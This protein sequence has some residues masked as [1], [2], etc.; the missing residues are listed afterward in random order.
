M[1]LSE[2]IRYEDFDSAVHKIEDKSSMSKCT[3]LTCICLYTLEA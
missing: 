2:P 1:V 3:I